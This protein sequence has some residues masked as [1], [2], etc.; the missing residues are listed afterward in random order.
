LDKQIQVWDLRKLRAEL[1]AL[2]LD[3]SAPPIP[4]E[5]AGPRPAP[6]PLRISLLETVSR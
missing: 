3:W 2:N 4:A 5:P 6:K 1:A